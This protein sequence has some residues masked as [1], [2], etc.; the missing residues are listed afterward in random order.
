MTKPK[1]TRRQFLEASVATTAGVIIPNWISLANAADSAGKDLRFGAIGVG[2]RG[3]QIMH[4]ALGTGAAML[5]IADVDSDRAAKAKQSTGDSAC[6]YVDY[7]K[8]LDRKDIDIV[9]IGTPDHWHSKIAIEAMQAGK[10]VYCEKPLTLTIDEGKLIR[11]VVK[12]TGR[13]FQVGT[14][15]RSEYD[16]KFL[17]AVA[18]CHAGRLGEI[19]R[20]TCAVGEG[21][22]GG[23]FK[24]QLPPANLDW[25]LWLGQAPSVPYIPERCHE[26]FRWWYEYSGGKM[27][28]WGAHHIDIAHWALR[29]TDTGPI[30]IQ[31][32][33]EFPQKHADG[34]NTATAL[35]VTCRFQNGAEILIVHDKKPD[36]DNGVLIEG[37]KGRLFVNRAKLTGSPVESL[38]DHPLPEDALVKLCKGKQPGNHMRNFMECVTD[39]SEPISDV[40][41]H[42]RSLTTCHLANIAIRLNRPIK[43]DPVAEQIVGDDDAN[44]WLQREQREPYQ[45][46]V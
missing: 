13:V 5:A 24:Q 16:L 7:R 28:D 21:L 40:N 43:W 12:E 14:Q 33:A 42:H 30:A 36:F 1:F 4:Y 8:V 17:K 35:N 45:I 27:T 3:T 26:S 46:Q 23:P 39:R 11:K 37:S 44:S 18:L 29:A 32:T 41:S 38:V 22:Q 6:T 9:I 25:D 15:Q 19:Q 34:F 10:D 20:I 2:G 31:G